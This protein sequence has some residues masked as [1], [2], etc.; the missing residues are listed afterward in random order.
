MVAGCSGA[1]E[2]EEPL[3]VDVVHATRAPGVAAQQAPAGKHGASQDATRHDRPHRVLRAA[4]VIATTRG[5]QR[6]ER[7]LVDHDRGRDDA[8]GD[9]AHVRVRA[10]APGALAEEGV[11]TTS[12]TRPQSAVRTPAKPSRSATS[13]SW[14]AR[15]HHDV[16][17]ALDAHP[18]ER[19]G[20]AEKPLDEVA[21]DGPTDLARDAQPQAGTLADVGATPVGRRRTTSGAG[22]LVDR[23]A[24]EDM[25]HKVAVGV[26][27]A[28]AVHALEL[29]RPG[30]ASPLRLRPR[31]G[32]ARRVGHAIS[33]PRR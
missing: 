21:L 7:P 16:D 6:G 12:S 8:T 3:I 14:G 28:P 5:Q 15:D 9:E 30:E 24:G 23:G 33:R 1:T 13:R 11:R 29:R 4:R 10:G 22:T 20:L 32:P 25:Q 31:A 17:R 27:P 26:R 2:R 18:L 19:P